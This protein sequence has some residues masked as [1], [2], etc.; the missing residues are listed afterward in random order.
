MVLG[1]LSRKGILCASR[2]GLL[3]T[4]VESRTYKQDGSSNQW[5][6]RD[7]R[8]ISVVAVREKEMDACLMNMEF[9]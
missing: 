6:S 1:D 4:K 3:V 2:K 8:Y 9:I 7:G 5:F